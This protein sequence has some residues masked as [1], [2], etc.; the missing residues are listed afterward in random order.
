ML[1]KKKRYIQKTLIDFSFPQNVPTSLR[2]V[3]PTIEHDLA[4][5][6]MKLGLYYFLR[7]RC[8][9]LKEHKKE[10]IEMLNKMLKNK[11]KLNSIQLESVQQLLKEVK[12]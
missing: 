11:H 2:L 10:W 6:R 12:G 8:G 1:K 4:L 5:M 3:N 7:N 9:T